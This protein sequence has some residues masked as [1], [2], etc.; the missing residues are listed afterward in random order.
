MGRECFIV[1]N[2]LRPGSQHC[3]NGAE[4]F[5]KR[6][7]TIMIQT[8]HKAKG[9][10]VRID[11]GHDSSDSIKAS[12]DLK[13]KYLMKSN[14]RKKTKKLLDSTRYYETFEQE[15]PERGGIALE[16]T[17]ILSNTKAL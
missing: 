12:S 16:N 1:A 17:R 3:E 8:E 2:E 7:I 15:R 13:I 4:K 9:L 5:F 14:L 6:C 10:L 11:S